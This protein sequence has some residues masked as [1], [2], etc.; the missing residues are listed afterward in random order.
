MGVNF[1]WEPSCGHHLGGV[2]CSETTLEV[3]PFRIH[4]HN[5]TSVGTEGE[6]MFFLAF[7]DFDT[8]DSYSVMLVR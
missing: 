3:V 6:H 5:S 2:S 7:D 8:R 1:I 4:S